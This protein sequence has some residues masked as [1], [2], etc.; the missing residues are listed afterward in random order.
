MQLKAEFSYSEISFIE[1]LNDHQARLIAKSKSDSFDINDIDDIEKDINDIGK[2]L[3]YDP[4]KHSAVKEML[5]YKLT[6]STKIVFE[7]YYDDEEGK[8]YYIGYI[9]VLY[10]ENGKYLQCVKYDWS[11]FHS[12][13]L[14]SALNSM[15][16]GLIVLIILNSLLMLLIYYRAISPIQKITRSILKYKNDKISSDVLENMSKIKGR[17][18]LCVLAESFSDLTSEIDRHTNIEAQRRQI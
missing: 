9:P 1:L 13:L 17:N 5:S 4:T 12:K 10:N 6:N 11:D 3:D 15:L 8:Y 16:I 14:K 18:E 2:I 7:E